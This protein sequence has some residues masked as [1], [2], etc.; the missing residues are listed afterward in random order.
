MKKALWLYFDIPYASDATSMRALLGYQDQ[1]K[2]S[3]LKIDQ[4]K[5]IPEAV[6]KAQAEAA[7]KGISIDKSITLVI[8]LDERMGLAWPVREVADKNSWQFSRHI[9]SGQFPP[10][11]D[12]ILY[13][14]YNNGSREMNME[15]E[16]AQKEIM[17]LNEKAQGDFAYGDMLPV[18]TA[19]RQAMSLSVHHFGWASPMA[20][21]TLRNLMYSFRA[22]G[23]SDNEFEG[24]FLVMQMIAAFKSSAPSRAAWNGS[25]F[26]LDNIS[27]NLIALG[28]T[29]LAAEIKDL[30]VKQTT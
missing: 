19:L 21:Y 7:Q 22:T 14:S 1:T 8:P 6:S 3:V 30:L 5:D 11:E 2:I 29:E 10:A 20:G 24:K 16:V 23:N 17:D 26:L 12:L 25:E 4:C 28:E 13:S 27:D 15:K 9:P 18:M